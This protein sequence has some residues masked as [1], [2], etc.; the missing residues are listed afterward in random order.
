MGV[1]PVASNQCEYL[2]QKHGVYYFKRK[3]PNDVQQHYE[4]P[5]IVIY[6]KTKSKSAAA[7]AS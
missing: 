2:W 5:Q 7:K 1:Y 3:V 6:L 4:R